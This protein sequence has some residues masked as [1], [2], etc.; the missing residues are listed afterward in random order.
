MQPTDMPALAEFA[1]AMGDTA[2]ILG[3]R[4]SQWCGHSPALEEDIA[5]A[6]TALDLIGQAQLWLGLAA[7]AEGKGR[8]PDNLA[9]LRDAPAYRNLLLVE[10]PNGDFGRTIMRQ[11]LFD[12]WHLPMLKA[13]SK[14]REVRVAEIAE[15]AAK[16]VAY[17][18]ERSADLVVRLGDGTDES[19]ARMQSA[20]DFLSPY[21]GEMFLADAADE[22]L[23]AAGIVPAPDTLRPAWDQHVRRMLADATLKL[24]EK[25]YVQKGGRRGVH[26][27][28]LGFILAEM[29]H[30]QRAYPGAAW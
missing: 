13:L 25:P 8:T 21:T 1:L 9:Y 2:L 12:A 22:E 20:L 16:E 4:N 24:P 5:L 18:L 6:N 7:D 11:Y 3:H 15:K 26:S 28:H 19:H 14:S 27:E 23:A 30:L 29:Q 17:H 10:Q